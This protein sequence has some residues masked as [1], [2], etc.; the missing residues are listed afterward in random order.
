MNAVKRKENDQIECAIIEMKVRDGYEK[1]LLDE[2]RKLEEIIIET[3]KAN[4]KLQQVLYE[5]ECKKY[6]LDM[7]N[8]Q[9]QQLVLMDS[10]TGLAN[11]RHFDEKLLKYINECNNHPFDFS[12][13][14]FDID[15]FKRINNHYGHQVGDI[16]LQELAIKAQI[17]AKDIGFVARI[18]GE[19]FAVL[20]PNLNTEEAV[21][22]AEHFR[23]K[24]EASSWSQV[25]ITISIGITGVN[26]N[27]T[28]QS[29][30]KRAD[31]ALYASKNN[32]RNQ[33]TLLETIQKESL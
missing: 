3:E 16:V 6:K 23:K 21:D 5:V 32:G 27:D 28:E 22:W 14:L 10:L 2:R 18:G 19:E 29:V 11:R 24:V 7:L 15:Y 31:D 9:L 25:A 17:H 26:Y 13:V 1:E 30:I 8:E 4:T 12:V 33:V 20:L